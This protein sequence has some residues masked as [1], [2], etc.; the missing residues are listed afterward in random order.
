MNPLTELLQRI[1]D[2]APTFR[3]PHGTK[4]YTMADESVP[5]AV[6]RKMAGDVKAQINAEMKRVAPYPTSR[7]AQEHR[8]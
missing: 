4:V 1:I 2:E 8:A 5:P 3:Y 6:L 7:T